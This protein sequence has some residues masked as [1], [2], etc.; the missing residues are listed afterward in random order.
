MRWSHLEYLL[1]GLF[2]SLVLY[3]AL[4]MSHD[5]PR[6]SYAE[7]LLRFNLPILVGL[8]LV[9]LITGGSKL[10]EGYRLKGRFWIFVFFLLLESPTL[11]YAGIFG[12]V[13]VGTY[14]IQQTAGSDLLLPVLGGGALLGLGFV[15]VRL[16]RV[17]SVRLVV[18]LLL[19]SA[20]AV[21]LYF[22]LGPGIP[23]PGESGEAAPPLH[24]GTRTLVRD[25]TLFAIQL[26]L[27][28][29]FFYVL[30]FAGRTEESEVEIGAI[31]AGLAV[32]LSILTAHAAGLAIPRHHRAR[33]SFT[34]GT[35]SWSCPL[36]V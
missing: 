19:A 5:P 32:G 17:R 13:I 9:L 26:V 36:C 11:V 35:P 28:L 23:L 20:L 8:L 14:L 4:Q 6:G 3:A 10:R 31:C 25:P 2:L 30:T 12:G 34:W 21:G 33:S 29:L 7:P 22:W 1:K 16:I 24:E 27:G 15:L 18:I